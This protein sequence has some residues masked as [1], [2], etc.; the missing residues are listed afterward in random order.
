MPRIINTIDKFI[1]I[2]WLL[3]FGLSPIFFCPWVYGTWQ[4]AEA[5]LFQ[6]LT[7]I[8]VFAWLLKL[9]F[10]TRTNADTD[11]ELRGKSLRKSAF[12]QRQSAYPSAVRMI[13]PAIIFIIVLGLATIFSQSPYQSFFGY[14]QRKMGYLMWLHLFIFFLVLFS[15]LK[16]KE[17]IQRIFYVICGSAAIVAI[18]GFMQ[19]FGW[20]IFPWSEQAYFSYRIFSTLGQPNFLASWLL[21]AIPVVIWVLFIL[22]EQSSDTRTNADGTQTN[23]ENFSV[24]QRR[25]SVSQRYARSASWRRAHMLRPMIFCLFLLIIFNLVLTQS[26]GG[27][28]GFLVAFF[29]FMIIFCCL[30]KQK[31]AVIMFSVFCF[32]LIVTG[33]Y[34]NLHP[35]TIKESDPAL[36][37][38]VKTLTQLSASGKLRLMWWK[39]SLDLIKQKP[40]LGYGPET[41]VF[42]FVRYYEPEFGALEAI[43]TYPDRAHNDILD[44]LL[45]SGILGLGAY[46]FLIGSAFYF[47]LR[48]I[49][50]LTKQLI[51][52]VTILALLAGLAGYLVSL[53]FSFHIIPTAIYFWGYLAIILK[54]TNLK[55]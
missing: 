45:I 43:N 18:Y 15:G 35:L 22:S 2:G 26:R 53:Q 32:L 14:Y 13:L 20:E 10:E 8:I 50:Q 46:L 39:N 5:F 34:F 40:I 3:I 37:V 24:S 12:S 6:I 44:T 16:S 36:V 27:W 4:V 51:N 28:F 38:R 49:T 42:N 41:Q 21:L 48:K 54:M 31:R 52:Q 30:K 55:Q 7:E 11:A 1:E 9:I 29:F 17:Q 25:V 19:I 47:G 23:A 33:F